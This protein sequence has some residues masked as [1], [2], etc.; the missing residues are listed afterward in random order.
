MGVIY[1]AQVPS[2]GLGRIEQATTDPSRSG[3]F[4]REVAGLTT[5]IGPYIVPPAAEQSP[6]MPHGRG[7]EEPSGHPDGQEPFWIA[8]IGVQDVD[9]AAERARHIGGHILLPPTEVPGLGRTAV[10]R[11]PQGLAFGIFTPAP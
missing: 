8:Y 5:A 11:D 6:G 1:V 9:A 2:S 7:T 4:Y 10:L 3:E